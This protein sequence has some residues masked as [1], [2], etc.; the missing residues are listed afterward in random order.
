MSKTLSGKSLCSGWA[1]GK[2]RYL[3]KNEFAVICEKISDVGTQIERYEKAGK[4]AA[5][6]VS[7]LYER[8][9]REV[10]PEQARIFEAQGMILVDEEFNAFVRYTITTQAV[11]AEYAVK[12]TCE[13]FEAM[14]LNMEDEYFRARSV[15][16]KDVSDRLLRI[17]KD[18]KN[19]SQTDEGEEE[20]AKNKS[21]S[22]KGIRESYIIIA[23]E[24]SPSETM[25]LEKEN[26]RGLVT[27][28]GAANSH[29]AIL[30]GTMNIPAL[31]EI[32]VSEDMDDKLAIIDGFLGKMI[33]EPDE[34]TLEYYQKKM[35]EESE[36]KELLLKYRGKKTVDSTGRRISI[37]ANIG[38]ISDL[39]AVLDNDAEGIGLFR[40]E[41]LYLKEM[42]YPNEEELFQNYRQ[43][44]ESMEGKKVIIRTLDVGADK[45]A[46]YLGLEKEDNP[47]LGYRGIRLCLTR[48]A[49]F[50]TQLRAMLRAGAYGNLALMYPM[51]TSVWEVRKV[52][53]LVEEIKAELNRDGMTYGSFEQGIMIETP[54][55]ALISDLLAE[56]VDFF[57]IGTNDLIQYT[58]AADRKNP[59]MENYYDV[60]HEAV[61]R[62]IRMTI[63][64]GHKAGIRVGMCGELAADLSL[65]ATFLKWGIDELS[66]APGKVLVIRKKVMES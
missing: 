35:K 24:L 12:A 23:Q 37:C 20:E 38:D 4:L 22:Q 2:I 44:L 31:S 32:D 17:L 18:L 61:L 53:A 54:A 14:F 57:S 1:I 47:A 10:G 60:H 56:E 43:V 16:V 6:E 33:L 66:V 48:E 46:E 8:A 11:N 52:K 51:I 58:L 41:M 34:E 9:L 63:E 27:R 65:T 13:H 28:H 30:A 21:V 40:S 25:Q 64:N 7:E 29:T 5:L 19:C 55:A 39:K 49:V 45:S 50:R 15:D 3:Q 36:R 62:L 59:Q 26:L 42:D